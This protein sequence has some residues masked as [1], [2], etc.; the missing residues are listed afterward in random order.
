MISVC[1]KCTDREVGCHA[2]CDKYKAEKELRTK[3]P[4]PFI[5]YIDSKRRCAK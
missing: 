1:Y 4:D 5:D 3:K 2:T